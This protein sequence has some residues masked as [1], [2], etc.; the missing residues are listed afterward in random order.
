MGDSHSIPTPSTGS[1]PEVCWSIYLSH[2]HCHY[3]LTKLI[4]RNPYLLIYLS[5]RYMDALIYGLKS[6]KAATRNDK[7][8]QIKYYTYMINEDADST[9][10]RLFEA[11]MESA[12]QVTLQLYILIYH[13]SDNLSEGKG[14]YN[15]QYSML[16]NI[17]GLFLLEPLIFVCGSIRILTLLYFYMNSTISCNWVVFVKPGLVLISIQ[18]VSQVFTTGKTKYI[19]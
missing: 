7:A 10:L 8:Q 5:I 19:L 6:R 18:S 16:Y 13:F 15:N 12:P 17:F 9:L 3:L 11:F 4:R 14:P 2:C 1:S